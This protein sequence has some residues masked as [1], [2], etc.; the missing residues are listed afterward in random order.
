MPKWLKVLLAIF[1]VLLLLCG[2]SAFFAKRWF[3]DNKDR[4]KA[5]GDTAAK[6][7]ATWAMTHDAH[8]CVDEALRRYD[9]E[10]GM[11]AE[12]GHTIFMRTC[13]DTAPRPAGFCD[14]VPPKNEIFQTAEWC[15]KKC[16][17]LNRP[18]SQPCTRMVK[19]I[20]ESCSRKP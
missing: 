16:V 15:V 6:D 2:A 8:S 5:L 19:A 7:G 3:D 9:A 13:L 11:V 1:A 4:L 17:A 18:G 12:A 14:G 20:Q 10:G